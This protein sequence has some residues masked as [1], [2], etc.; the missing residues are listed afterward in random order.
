MQLRASYTGSQRRTSEWEGGAATPAVT[1]R[2]G[3]TPLL[4]TPR[5]P[6]KSKPPLGKKAG[7]TTAVAGKKKQQEEA[8]GEKRSTGHLTDNLLDI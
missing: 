3:P 4:G 1:P 5:L 2:L 6:P 7:A 8:A